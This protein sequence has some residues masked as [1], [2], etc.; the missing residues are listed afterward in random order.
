MHDPPVRGPDKFWPWL[1]QDWKVNSRY[2][3][4]Q[5]IL[6]WFRLAQWSYRRWGRPGLVLS[7]SYRLFTSLFFS[8]ELPHQLLVGPRLRL[9]HPHSIVL[10]PGVRL[11]S[12]CVLRQ[13]V[14]I[15][16]VMRRDG[17][18]KGVA[19]AGDGVEFG[20][21]CVVVG[22]LHVGDHARIGALTLV[23]EDVP[24]RGVVV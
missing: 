9:Y 4:S 11:G 2:P 13:N 3:D 17:T 18:E 10:N 5:L 23:L 21:G 8:I 24:A 22:D 6:L 12:D 16:N 20:A 15:G 7:L 19:S 14:T 1:F